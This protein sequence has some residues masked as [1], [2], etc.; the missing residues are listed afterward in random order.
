MSRR[1]GILG[2]GQ[3]ARMLAVAGHPLGLEFRCYDEVGSAPADAVTVRHRGSFTDREAL[4]RF[5]EGLD[6]VTWEFENVPLETVHLLEPLV[7]VF[8]PPRSLEV[9]QD[10]LAEKMFFQGLGIPTA[11][12]Q[13][14]DSA[15]DLAEATEALGF[16]C[17]LKTRRFG[18]DGKGQFVL[19]EARDR[20]AAWQQLGGVALI[21]EGFVPFD[22]ELS[23]LA[24]R[25]RS[26]AIGTWPLV[27]NQHAEGI[28]RV[29]RSPA[30][31]IGS[32]L[33]ELARGYVERVLEEL[34]YVGV[35]AIELFQWGDS[36]LAN[37]MAP[38]VHNS[39]HG[40]IEGSVTSQFENH[41]RA[42]LDWPLGLTRPVGC[43]A[44][45]NLIGEV[46]EVK[47][48]LSVPDCHLHLY[49]KEPRPGR[50]LGHVTIHGESSETVEPRLAEI[51]SLIGSR[52]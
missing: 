26:G 48:L 19:R 10:R 8:P 15:A 41:L 3:L 20:A 31:G 5:A 23:I 6:L 27:E 4:A 2:A 21:L 36:L 45:V 28:L 42:V 46:P 32:G 24:A 11:P 30:P 49:G 39:G 17:V 51:L 34:E 18:Y 29:S 9:G 33:Q 22:R 14:V 43:T 16:P 38:R 1:I 7:P 13:A 44:M 37:E 40:S 35:L 25:S 52:G 12:F 50:K 47:N